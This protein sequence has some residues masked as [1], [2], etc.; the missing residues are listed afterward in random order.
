MT[1]VWNKTVTKKSNGNS[2]K[3]R[4]EGWGEGEIDFSQVFDKKEVALK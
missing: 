3:E 2:E 4:M 1:K